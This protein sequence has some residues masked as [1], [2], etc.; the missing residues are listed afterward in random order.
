MS[1]ELPP[2]PGGFAAGSRLAGY[3]C[4]EEIGRGGMAVVYRAYDD[5]LDRRVA[6]KLLAPELARDE[7]FRQR[8]IQESRIA[9]AVD[10][11]NIIP[12]F[13]AG[14]ADGV[15]FIAM[16]YVPDGDV[17]TL[18]D[19]VGPLPVARVCAILAQVASALDA[20]HARGLVHRDVK[21]TNMLLEVSSRH[22]RPDHVYLSDFGLAK[23]S[24]AATGLTMTGQFFGTVDYVAPEQ[25]Q[26][27]PLNGRTDQY[28]LACAA[29]EMLCGA[30]PFKGDNGMAV[31]SAQLSEPPPTLTARRPDLPAA[32]DQVIAK[33]LAK[34]PADRYDRCLDFAEALLAACRSGAVGAGA[35]QPPPAGVPHSPTRL[36]MPVAPVTRPDAGGAEG[37]PAVT[38]NAGGLPGTGVPGR[39]GVPASSGVPASPGKPTDPGA[40]GVEDFPTGPP[41]FPPTGGAPQPGGAWQGGAWPGGPQPD[42]A[43]Q[44]GARPGGPQPGEAQPGGAQPDGPQSGGAWQGGAW[45]GEAWPGEAQPGGPYPP[46]GGWWAGQSWPPHGQDDRARIRRRSRGAVAAS[47]I[48]LL[49]VLFFAAAGVTYLVLR[50]TG[51][52]SPGAAGA[53]APGSTASPST[54]ASPS[55]AASPASAGATGNPGATA[56]ASGPAVPPPPPPAG[57]P[58]STVLAYFSAINHHRYARAWRLGG[59]N[60]GSTYSSF[61]SGFST[62]A[63]DTVI[64]QSVSGNVVTAQISALQT[65]GTTKTYQGTYTVTNGVITGFNVQQ[66]G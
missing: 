27:Q 65:D 50:G 45:P 49:A 6:L 40:Q 13:D 55:A 38:G 21:P 58:A 4:E 59:K 2:V 54:T 52:S 44:G 28:A 10:H 32:A 56:S 5:R 25:I 24:S 14:E 1:E 46:T 63:H 34:A 33:A 47:V 61:V 42:R 57:H 20:A 22:S 39:P 62:T 19:Q 18:I 17:R 11:P 37:S 35:G 51:G 36:A 30:P 3:R 43:W 53:P 64:I 29:F 60:T 15:L 23:P 26:G 12:V 31:I 41:A 48:A 16:R 9:A 7:L 8:F 66:T